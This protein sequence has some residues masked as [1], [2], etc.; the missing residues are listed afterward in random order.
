MKGK[1]L[2]RPKMLG[3]EV[4]KKD[5]SAQRSCQD[6]AWHAEEHGEG[7]VLALR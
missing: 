4:K 2:T 3:V 1:R 7:H 5:R 6:G